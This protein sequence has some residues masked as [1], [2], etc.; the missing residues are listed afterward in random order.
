[1]NRGK[2][3]IFIS[4]DIRFFAEL[5]E[6]YY[7]A[8]VLFAESMIY[9]R[10]E[11]KDIV[12][13]V[14]TELW[15]KPQKVH[16]YSKMKTYLFSCVKNKCFNRLKKLNII[17]KHQELLTE[18]Y[19]FSCETQ[20][21]VNEKLKMQIHSTLNNMPNTM[22]EVLNM[23]V[24]Q[25]LKYAEIAE[26]LKISINSVKTH[27]KRAYKRFRKEVNSNTILLIIIL[28]LLVFTTL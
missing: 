4:K 14:F 22:R 12:Q 2:N 28:L 3:K 20:T 5:Y 19:L 6:K 24:I 23:H 9:D 11:A 13:D 7:S 18:A 25:E 15:N 21:H 27:I 26:E 8:M 16:V 17:D 10:D 1:M